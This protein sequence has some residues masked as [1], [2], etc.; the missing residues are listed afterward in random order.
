M[1]LHSWLCVFCLFEISIN[2]NQVIHRLT[3]LCHYCALAQWYSRH[4]TNAYPGSSE[5]IRRQLLSTR[6]LNTPTS[7]LI[8]CFVKK[9]I[10]INNYFLYDICEKYAIKYYVFHQNIYTWTQR[11]LKQ[12]VAL[13]IKYS[14]YGI[15]KIHIYIK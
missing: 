4:K 1:C 10:S 14:S 15:L 13:F 8:C 7:N 2:S 5:L 3:C 6:L 11:V 9:I 12:Q